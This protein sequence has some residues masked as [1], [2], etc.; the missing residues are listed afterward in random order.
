MDSL[1]SPP[2]HSD[3]FVVVGID[4]GT[5][6]MGLSAIAVRG[7]K[8]ELLGMQAIRFSTKK[9]AL[10]RLQDI[11]AAVEEWVQ[12]FQPHVVALEAPFFGKNVQSMLKLG[13][14]QGVAMGVA[15]SRSLPVFEYSPT[16][17]KQSI[18]GSGGATKEKVAGMLQSIYGFKEL[19]KQ[20]DATDGLAVATCYAFSSFSAQKTP[21]GSSIVSEPPAAWKKGMKKRAGGAS[22]NAWSQ[23]VDQNPT[24]ILP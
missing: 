17:V 10:E 21:V 13:R 9:E 2:N 23:F 8:L 11:H 22:K 14:A 3:A 6:V 19:P 5:V 15:L 18:T 12:R 16:R 4:P 7:Q 20:L 24:K 1:L